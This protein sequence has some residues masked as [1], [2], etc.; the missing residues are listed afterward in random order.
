MY[1]VPLTYFASNKLKTITLLCQSHN[2]MHLLKCSR[3]G[4]LFWGNLVASILVGSL[5]GGL[6]FLCLW[7]VTIVWIQ[8]LI[9]LIIGVSLVIVVRALFSKYCRATFHRGFY[10]IR[11]FE[12]NIVALLNSCLNFALSTATVLIR[13]GKLLVLASLYVGRIDTPFVAHKVGEYFGGWIQLEGYHRW[14]IADVLAVEAHRHPY[15]ETLGKLHLLKLKH[16]KFM[17]SLGCMWRDIFV[18]AMMPW[19]HKYR[20]IARE[21]NNKGDFPVVSNEDEY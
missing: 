18:I 16:P 5:F 10:R 4:C 8:R 19:L 12:A 17:T 6:A 20:L 2:I 11:P 9:A 7:Q 1:V 14:F 3:L 15:L 21:E 13:M